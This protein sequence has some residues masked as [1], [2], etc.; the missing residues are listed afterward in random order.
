MLTSAIDRRH[1]LLILDTGPIRELVLYHAVSEFGFEK[2][3][4]E[5][6]FIKDAESYNRNRLTTTAGVVVELYHWIRATEEHGRSKLWGR[7][8]DEFQNMGMDEEL[9]QLLL[10]DESLVVRCG[11]VDASLLQ[12]ARLHFAHNPL[13]L[14]VDW[15]FHG[16]CTKS[17]LK[18]SHLDEITAR[19]A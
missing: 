11:P 4:D 9:V 2:L 14:T 16:E 8:Y 17:G 5:L 7:V 1:E 18:V 13:I 12:L 6:R 15:S 3:R 10:M 19:I